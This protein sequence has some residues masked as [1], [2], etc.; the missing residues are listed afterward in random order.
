MATP[1]TFHTPST[2]NPKVLII[3]AGMGGVTLAL[4]LEKANIDY[5]IY[6][7]AKELK[8]V[9]SAIGIAPNVMPMMEQLGLLDDI[10][11]IYQVFK[12]MDVYNES[13]DG[14]TLELSSRTEF[15]ELK[16]LSG[17]PSVSMSRPEFHALLISRVP[18]HKLHLGKRVLSISQDDETG[19]L[20]RT[21]DGMSHEGDILV[22]AD[23]AYSSVRHSLYKQ[24]ANEGLLP[25]SDA[26][27]L[28]VCHMSILGTSNPV[29]PA[30]IP[31]A[32]DGLS[33]GCSV[34]GHNKP[35]SLPLGANGG[36]VTIGDL[37]DNTPQ[38]NITKVM[39]E[40]KLYNT[41]YHRRT[42]LIGDACHKMLPNAGRGAVNAMLDAVILANAIYEIGVD[43]TPRNIQSAFREYFNERFPHAKADLEASQKMAKL[44]AG[45]TWSDNLRRKVVFKF[46]PASLMRSYFTRTL[47]YRPQASFL[48]KVECRGSVKPEP[49][50][51]SKRYQRENAIAV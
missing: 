24:L 50:K 19:V 13:P 42:V 29:D 10:K 49:Q 3:G 30:L 31:P 37:V 39:L 20:I 44:N 26:E 8:A 40:E 47:A 1:S 4:L 9:G 5:E 12:Q 2:S 34:V 45:Q 41:W 25:S 38:E 33:R 27:D 16:E 21:S 28:K 46:M 35:H 43:A 51:K 32:E 14:E 11:G 22:G 6:E 18:A 36:Y 17:Y 15:S 7:R 23:G 48:P